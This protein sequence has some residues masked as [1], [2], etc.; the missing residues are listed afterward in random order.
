MEFLAKETVDIAI[1]DVSMPGMDGFQ[2]C[3]EIKRDDR[4]KNI[5]VILM[6]GDMKT[7]N[8]E[9]GLDVGAFDYL[10]KPVDL[11]ECSA[12]MH[13]AIQ[14]K[15]TLDALH[16]QVLNPDEQRQAQVELERKQAIF[17][18]GL[19]TTHWNVRF[20]QIAASFLDEIR[21]PLGNAIGGVQTISV[22]ESVREEI[23]LR[24]RLLLPQLR[25]SQ[26]QLRRLIN[27]AVYSRSVQIICPAEVASDVAHLLRAE[28]AYYGIRLDLQLDPSVRWIGMK[29]EL[30]RAILYLIQNA[31]EAHT[32]RGPIIRQRYEDCHEPE[33]PKYEPPKNPFISLAV[34]QTSSHIVV[35]VRDNGPGIKPDIQD[36]IWDSYFTTRQPPH[37][38]AGLHIARA[39]IRAA[40]GDIELKSPGLDC[41]TQFIIKLPINVTNPDTIALS[42][43]VTPEAAAAADEASTAAEAETPAEAEAVPA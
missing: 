22:D 33:P 41:S 6:T 7:E 34:G 15:Q 31:I 26:R 1:V 40:G 4:T 28:F 30:S 14:M 21:V 39:I 12:R 35:H 36:K 29:S 8:T 19:M 5:V 2:V 20:G 9:L 32:D 17:R 16:A 11:H 42:P 18:Q 43:V 38:G 13:A 3:R 25:D 24:A 37:T 23:R 27:I 10:V